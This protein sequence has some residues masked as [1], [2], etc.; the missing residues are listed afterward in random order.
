MN[1]EDS[2]YLTSDKK[3][4]YITDFEK[5]SFLRPNDIWSIDEGLKE[6]LSLINLHQDFQTIYSKLFRVKSTDEIYLEGESYLYLTAFKKSWTELEIKLNSVKAE[7]SSKNVNVIIEIC[8][9]CD[10]PNFENGQFSTRDIACL[11]SPDYFRIRHFKIYI[12]TT[13]S[14]QH[15]TFWNSI[16]SEFS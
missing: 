2:I 16:K 10:N 3:Q 8:E 1:A 7:C 15:D 6:I 14:A 4:F 5:L 12:D 11:K 13:V 9:P